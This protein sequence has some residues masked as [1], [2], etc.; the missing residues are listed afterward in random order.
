MIDM[1]PE[2]RIGSR[3]DDRRGGMRLGLGWI[4]TGKH[5]TMKHP[6]IIL[7]IPRDMMRGRETGS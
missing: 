3:L 7:H 5:E 6:E 4:E 1:E 2:N